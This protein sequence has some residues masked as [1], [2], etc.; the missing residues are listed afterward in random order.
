W[1]G[2]SGAPQALGGAFD[3]ACLMGCTRSGKSTQAMV[4]F[5]YQLHI[6]L[7]MKNPQGWYGLSSATSI[8][9]AIMGAKPHVTKKVVYAPLKKFVER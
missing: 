1:R 9:M 6:L 8:V 7:C 2:V 3:T 4:G 5:L